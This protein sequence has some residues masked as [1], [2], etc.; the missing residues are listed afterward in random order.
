MGDEMGSVGTPVRVIGIRHRIKFSAAGEPRPTQ[1]HVV[2]GDHTQTYDLPNDD[3]ELD[4]VLGAYPT[5]FRKA[6]DGDNLKLPRP[7]HVRWR[8]LRKNEHPENFP[9]NLLSQEGKTWHVA[10]HIAVDFDGLRA[11]DTIAMV[12]GGSGDRFAY[13]LSRRAE[14]IGYDTQVVRI[15]PAVLLSNR[16]HGMEEDARNLAELFLDRPDLFQRVTPRERKLIALIEAWRIRVDTMKERIACEQRLRQRFIG[17][18][19]C[20]PEGRY[21]EGSIEDQYNALAASDKILE[22]L[23][24]EER[25]RDREV[26]QALS[27][28]EVYTDLLADVEG[29]G[30]SIAA[31]L[32]VAIGDIQR[33]PS[34]AKLRAFCGVHVLPDGRF[35]R[36]RSGEL[37]NWHPDA[38]QALYLCMDQWNKRPDSVWG[39]QYRQNKVDYRRLHPEPTTVWLVEG[40]SLPLRV[41]AETGQPVKISVMPGRFDYILDA[42]DQRIMGTPRE[43]T[44]YTDIHI[45]KTAGWRTASQFVTWLWEEWTKLEQKTASEIAV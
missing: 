13:A 42:T 32:I 21:P 29:V 35:P 30:Q 16:P 41:D 37:A 18:V 27:A 38:R 4:F 36:R 22:A 31:R 11:G 25:A 8:L 15:P 34:A 6:R 7:S 28:I 20:S 39:R 1:V 43:V 9:A 2:D 45:H 10:T 44:R 26:A 5:E 23:K 33:F 40:S 17:K 19:F 24:V 14:E 3:A 12:R